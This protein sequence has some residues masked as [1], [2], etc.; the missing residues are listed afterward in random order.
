MNMC[1]M[2]DISYSVLTGDVERAYEEAGCRET[3]T[4]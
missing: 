1:I 2:M 3:I 4:V